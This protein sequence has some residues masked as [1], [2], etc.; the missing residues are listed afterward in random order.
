MLRTTG[1]NTEVIEPQYDFLQKVIQ[2]SSNS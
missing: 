1:N 2:S